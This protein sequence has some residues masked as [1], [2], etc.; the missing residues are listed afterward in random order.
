MLL[1]P[2]SHPTKTT[3]PKNHKKNS[4]VWLVNRILELES[5]IN[6]LTQSFEC[7]TYTLNGGKHKDKMDEYDHMMQP[8][9]KNAIKYSTVKK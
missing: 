2:C 7:Y 4:Q 6:E 8:I 5:V 9:W 3:T 1:T